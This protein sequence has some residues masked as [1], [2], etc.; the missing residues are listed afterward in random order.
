MHDSKKWVERAVAGVR[1][2]GGQWV[3]FIQ[4]EGS[5]IRPSKV[6]L[7]CPFSISSEAAA[8]V[9]SGPSTNVT[10]SLAVR[11]GFFDGVIPR[12]VQE[13][14]RDGNWGITHIMYD[15]ELGMDGDVEKGSFGPRL[16]KETVFIRSSFI[17]WYFDTNFRAAAIFTRSHMPSG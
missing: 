3:V 15:P 12:F 13:F 6:G 17:L 11:W 10:E 1:R 5:L 7:T 16:E 8:F 4:G 2:D 9:E 14:E